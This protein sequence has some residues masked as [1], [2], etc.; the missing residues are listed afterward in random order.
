MVKI[1]IA[2]TKR[3][4]VISSKELKKFL[5]IKNPEKITSFGCWEGRSPKDEQ[6]GVDPDKYE[7]WYISTIVEDIGKGHEYT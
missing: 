3:N 1:T 7:A 2:S 4:Y 6:D 5:G